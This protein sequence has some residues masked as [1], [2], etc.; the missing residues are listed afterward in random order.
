MIQRRTVLSAG[1]LG[2]S[3]VTGAVFGQALPTRSI[4]IV[5]PVAVGGGT[6][7][8][9][10]TLGQKVSEVLGQPV[11]IDNK[12]GAGGNIGAEFVM[13]AK[14]DGQTLLI[15]PGT[16]ATNVA[17]YRKLPYDLTKDFQAITLIGQTPSVLVV[18]PSVKANTVREFAQLLRA[19]PGIVNFGSAGTGSPHHLHSEFFNQLIGAK[20]N[21]I[22]YKGQ[23]QAMND[24][25]GGQIQYLFSPLQN[26][27]QQIQQGRVRALGVASIQR[28]THLPNVPTFIELGYKE[29]DLV[30]WFAVLAPANVPPAIVQKLY[31]A[32]SKIGN[33]ADT[34][35]KL[36]N[37]GFETRFTNP[38]E[39]MDFMRS[40][41]VRWARVAAY[42]GIQP[43]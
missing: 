35:D 12:L 33:Q 9:A 28:S 15:T 23:S 19:Q 39:T 17:A 13:K 24:L 10:R 36:T 25:L 30:H 37:L 2:T 14:P 34:K 38:A 8:L 7:L 32:F 5:V 11:V 41:L 16:I 40:E 22:P 42:A 31:A 29:M 3:A 21:H 27:L 20:S 6:D 43:E 1:L 4:Q 26:A 18:H